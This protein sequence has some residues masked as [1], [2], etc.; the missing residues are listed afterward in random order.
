MISV[1]V[2]LLDNFNSGPHEVV[3]SVSKGCSHLGHP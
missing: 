2:A 1:S 3:I